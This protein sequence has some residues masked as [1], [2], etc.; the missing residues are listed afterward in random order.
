MPTPTMPIGLRSTTGRRRIIEILTEHAQPMSIPEILAIDPSLAQSSVYRNLTILDRTGVVH[1]IRPTS[2]AGHARFK[3]AP[4]A[5]VPV[6]SI[7]NDCGHVEDLG[8]AF[9]VVTLTLAG[10]PVVTLPATAIN[11]STACTRDCP[12]GADQ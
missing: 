5:G 12:Q 10:A 4:A 2:H 8:E 9:D 3:L 6:H 11:V 1:T 7:C